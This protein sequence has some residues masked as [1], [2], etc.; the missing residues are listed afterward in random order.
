MNSSREKTTKKKRSNYSMTTKPLG[1]SPGWLG[2]LGWIVHHQ[3][4]GKRGV[5]VA[6]RLG[7]NLVTFK[8]GADARK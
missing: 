4:G 7:F 8:P 5:Q 6:A 3:E 2:E 1:F